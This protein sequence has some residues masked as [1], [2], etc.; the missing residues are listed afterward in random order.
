MAGKKELKDSEVDAAVDA[1]MTSLGVAAVAESPE[2]SG[3]DTENEFSVKKEV[4]LAPS[5]SADAL[6]GAAKPKKK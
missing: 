4:R 3:F 5:A 2:G 6:W 1:L